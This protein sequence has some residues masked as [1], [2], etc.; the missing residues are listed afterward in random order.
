[1]SAPVQTSQAM[2]FN[3][4]DIY[5]LEQVTYKL[6]NFAYNMQRSNICGRK[7]VPKRG[8]LLEQATIVCQQEE[9][10]QFFV[11][12]FSND[13][14]WHVLMLRLSIRVTN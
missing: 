3:G 7:C 2:G 10:R 8:Y 11:E 9:F 1:M 13:L 6:L 14:A 4:F 5:I 12:S